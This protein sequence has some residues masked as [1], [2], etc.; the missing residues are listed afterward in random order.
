APH[1]FARFYRADDAAVQ[2]SRG[3]GLGL[4]IVRATLSAYGG[5]VT[6]R[7]AG[8]GK[9]STFEV[10]LARCEGTNVARE[11]GGESDEKKSAT[12]PAAVAAAPALP[13][14][15]RPGRV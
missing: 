3:C 10:S 1:L 7:S 6:A 11:P 2:R 9:G 15:A 4:A 14:P 12:R 13:E 5:D 8:R